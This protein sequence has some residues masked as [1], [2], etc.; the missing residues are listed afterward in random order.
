MRIEH[1]KYLTDPVKHQELKIITIKED[2]GHITEGLLVNENNWFPIVAGV[3]RI[4]I[5]KMRTDYLQRH[6][7]LLKGWG[8]YLTDQARTE[9]QRAV[10][11]IE[12]MNKFDKH[13]AKT[14]ASFAWEWKNIYKE[15]DFEKNN[16][17]HFIGPFI[18]EESL[19]D[20]VVLDVGCGS[21]R[22]T[23]QALV[24]GAAIAVGV[25]VG[26]SVDVA[27]AM[28]KDNPNACIIQADV[29]SM[30]FKPVFDI[31]YSIGV[32]HHLPQPQQGFDQ[33]KHY[34]HSG[35]TV[36]IWVYNRRHNKR[37]IYLYEPVRSVVKLLPKPLVL[38]LS[39]PPAL[40][41]HVLNQITKW[42]SKM[43]KNNIAKKI[44]FSYYANFSFNM[45]LN[46]TFDVLATPKSNYYYVEE[47]RRWFSEAGLQQIEAFEHPE[48]GITCWGE[49]N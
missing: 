34:V 40:L 31:V 25:D 30:P 48:A 45:K 37:A 41:A 17:L 18:T 24:C 1:L 16:F 2:A 13:L 19:K 42:L 22:F 6:H 36:A 47:I 5:G 10:D 21:G 3:P 20:Q 46:D 9:W 23:K 27:F 11:E 43:G 8:S 4:L 14:G 28:T 32:L 49:K 26:E 29:Y 44:P 33:L 12:D 38:A 39:Y 15:N 35:G 7:N